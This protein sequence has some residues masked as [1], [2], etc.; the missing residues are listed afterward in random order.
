[1][2]HLETDLKVVVVKRETFS[3]VTFKNGDKN[4]R[5]FL[6]EQGSN[7]VDFFPSEHP[8]FLLY[9]SGTTGKPKGLVHSTAGY[10]L[11]A[12]TSF[13]WVF[14]KEEKDVF[15]CTADIGWITGHSYVVYGPLANGATVFLYE[16]APDFPDFGR[17][18]RMIESEKITILYTAPTAIRS[19]MR[20]DQKWVEQANLASL[21]LLGS[22]G[23]P[24]NPEAWEWYFKF[25]GRNK[26][27]IV[28]TWWQ[29]ETGGIVMCPLPQ[30]EPMKPGCAMAA[31]PG[32]DVDVVN[33]EGK[34]VA[35]G[36]QGSLVLKSP[37]PS[38]ARTVYGDPDRYL[39]TYWSQFHNPNE[40]SS[41]WYFSGDGAFR[42]KDGHIWIIG[43]MD[44]VMNV[45]GHRIGTM[46][47]ESALGEHPFVAESAVVGTPDAIKGTAI[48]AFV[49]LKSSA[50]SKLKASEETASFFEDLR[51]LVAK[52]IGSFA[53]PHR[54][55]ILEALP[56]TRSGKIMRR[57]LRDVASGKAISGDTSTL[58]DISMLSA[59]QKYQD[60]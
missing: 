44:D 54:I 53:K 32:F 48:C 19:F 20:Q 15:W 42:D 41:P 46:E 2:P 51:S 56:K 57:L 17:Y 60:E 5:P 59:L 55:Q 29:T 16:G 25:V 47:I 8:L 50:V 39:K 24:I 40:A 58:E 27:P 12:K 33:N 31:L 30:K 21:R 28:D 52:E 4:E 7:Q 18:W 34:S 23:E 35:A 1:L 13:E 49:L 38:Q 45:A 11:W 9:T 14:G 3:C 37:W 10:L 36:E 22:V 6:P 26:C 43:R